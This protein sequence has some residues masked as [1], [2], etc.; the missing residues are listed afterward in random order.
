MADLSV[1]LEVGRV[2]GGRDGD[3]CSLSPKLSSALSMC[4]TKCHFGTYGADLKA[5]GFHMGFK[6]G[7]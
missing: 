2:Y 1:G 5:K 7:L 6:H 3:S 4:M